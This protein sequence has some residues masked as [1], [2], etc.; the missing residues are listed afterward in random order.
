MADELSP[1]EELTR[2]VYYSSEYRPDGAVK[3]KVFEPSKDRETSVF[4][5]GGMTPQARRE[6]GQRYGRQD[7]E[8]KGYALLHVS[9]CTSSGLSTH[10]AEPPPRHAAIRSWPEARELVLQ[11]AQ[12]LAAF[13]SGRNPLKFDDR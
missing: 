11:K 5:L 13:A 1:D 10:L 2:F 4:L 7:R 3:P 9:D 6:H 12:L 8:A